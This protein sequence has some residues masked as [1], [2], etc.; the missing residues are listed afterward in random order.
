V[1]GEL[2]TFAYHAT[3]TPAPAPAVFDTRYDGW[4]RSTTGTARR[5]FHARARFAIR[6][7]CLRLEA[8]VMLPGE[9]ASPAPEDCPKF[10]GSP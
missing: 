10:K 6:D 1:S 2:E 4:K 5:V 3:I 8:P 9:R 7:G